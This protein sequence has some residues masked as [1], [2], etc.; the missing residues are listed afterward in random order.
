MRPWVGRSRTRPWTG[1]R[2]SSVSDGPRW[3]AM[4]RAP[5]CLTGRDKS[6]V[7]VL[8]CQAGSD[9]PAP[10]GRRTANVR[11]GTLAPGRGLKCGPTKAAAQQLED[12]LTAP[13]L[14]LVS[15]GR[16][17]RVRGG[18][19]PWQPPAVHY[20][21]RTAPVPGVA[22]MDDPMHRRQAARRRHVRDPTSSWQAIMT[23]P[24]TWA[25]VKAAKA[26]WLD[27]LQASEMWPTS[28]AG[29]SNCAG[30]MSRPRAEV[31][32]DGTYVMDLQPSRR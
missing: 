1:R 32:H 30:R 5:A 29:M 4:L 13:V 2:P 7:R 28:P 27:V 17:P 12:L 25:A 6:V 31:Y 11:S 16:R 24:P 23:P 15:L 21:R 26:T 18:R 10:L 22:D 9:C 8:R 20:S 3:V 19:G 14:L